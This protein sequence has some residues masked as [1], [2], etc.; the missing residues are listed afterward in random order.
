MGNINTPKAVTY[1]K[2]SHYCRFM[3]GHSPGRM[4]GQRRCTS[5]VVIGPV[6]WCHSKERA[7]R[8]GL[9]PSECEASALERAH[10]ERATNMMRA[11]S[12]AHTRWVPRATET[13]AHGRLAEPWLT[14]ERQG[15]FGVPQKVWR[16]SGF[17]SSKRSHVTPL[18]EA[19][20]NM[21]TASCPPIGFQF[22]FARITMF[23]RL[24]RRKAPNGG[25]GTQ[26]GPRSHRRTEHGPR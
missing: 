10:N 26:C 12:A 2:Q 5:W 9:A 6:P 18:I 24:R 16:P 3:I 8:Q 4:G 15:A 14:K 13:R 20:H 7:S 11:G 22:Y 21:H 19:W 25:G 23:S 1:H 17:P